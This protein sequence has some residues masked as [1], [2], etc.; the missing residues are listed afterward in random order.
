MPWGVVGGIIAAGGAIASSAINSSASSNAAN[1]EVQAANNASQTQENM[2]NATAGLQAP[3]R[4]LG[5]GADALL[6]QLYGI[7]NP[8]T[9][10]GLY[11]ANNA[12]S[13]TGGATPGA[14]PSGAPGSGYS[15]SG[16][17]PVP[18]PS[19]G[20]SW[21][22]APT[23]APGGFGGAGAGAG[24]SNPGAPAA[25]SANFSNFYNSPG[26]Q[27]TLNQGEQAIGRA[28]SA[29]GNL[30]STNTLADLNN[31]AQG[32]AS[33]QYNNYVQQLLSLAGIGGQAVAGTQAAGTNAANNISN[34]QLLSGGANASGILGSAGAL[35]SGLNSLTNPNGAFMQS[36]FN[37]SW[38]GGGSSDPATYLSN[39]YAQG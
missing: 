5:Y 8:N 19:G 11:P 20:I 32:V 18:T 27:F 9:S 21:Q 17:V 12:L 14:A 26:Y 22:L 30:Y 13:F 36:I 29:G 15:S 37:G 10:S 23:G 34:N 16:M 39:M 24:T 7:P 2:F 33:T 25:G 1:A 3:G 28:A 31:Y 35:N 6:A 38:G 4:N